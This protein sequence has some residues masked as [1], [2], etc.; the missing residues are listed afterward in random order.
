[1]RDFGL[2]LALENNFISTS[3]FAVFMYGIIRGTLKDNVGKVRLR[4]NGQE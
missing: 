2:R 4:N 1:M 3:S